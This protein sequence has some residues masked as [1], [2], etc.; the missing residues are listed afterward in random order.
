MGEKHQ[1]LVTLSQMYLLI[2]LEPRNPE[3]WFI[4]G[5][6]SHQKCTTPTSSFNE[7]FTT[8]PPL[9]HL[10]TWGKFS[11]RRIRKE[12]KMEVCGR[13]ERA[14]KVVSS[15]SQISSCSCLLLIQK[16]RVRG[17]GPILQ[18]PMEDP[19]T[20]K[21]HLSSI[22]EDPLNHPQITVCVLC[23]YHTIFQWS[24]YGQF[25]HYWSTSLFIFLSTR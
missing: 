9:P 25:F 19:G 15:G 8:S 1:T 17:T 10:M 4:W 6:S 2:A 5:E 23:M 24:Q 14:R 16:N 21:Y 13:I 22:K 12:G 7:V 20:P 3:S 18:L 11:D